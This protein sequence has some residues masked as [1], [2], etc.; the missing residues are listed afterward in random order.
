MLA[1][2]TCQLIHLFLP[3]FTISIYVFPNAK[4]C[5][6]LASGE[7]I[8]S[9]TEIAIYYFKSSFLQKVFATNFGSPE[10]EGI[11][12]RWEAVC[13]LKLGGT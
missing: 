11:T 5:W 8:S 2:V 12:T 3:K 13:L 7:G 10:S 4:K 1:L 6:P 9:C